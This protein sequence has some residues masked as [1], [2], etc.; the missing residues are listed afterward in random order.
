M[1]QLLRYVALVSG[2]VNFAKFRATIHEQLPEA[3]SIT[4]IIAE[5]LRAEGH[6]RGHAEGRVQGRVDMLSELLSLKFGELSDEHRARLASA[7]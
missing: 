6:N 3:D 4:M 7:T 5:Q 1:M 2:D